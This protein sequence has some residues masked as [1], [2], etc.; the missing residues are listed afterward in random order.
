MNFKRDFVVARGKKVAVFFADLT[1]FSCLFRWS[2]VLLLAA[3]AVC[4][5]SGRG[6][7]ELASKLLGPCDILAAHQTPCVAAHSVT[8]RMSAFY[9][10]SLFQ[11]QRASD[12]AT[13]EIGSLPSG[14]VDQAAWSAFCSTTTCHYSII[15]DQMNTPNFGNN[16]SQPTPANQAPLKRTTLPN[17][18]SLPS[19][20]TVNNQ[21]YRNRSNTVGLPTGESSIT[22]YYVRSAS[23]FS[24]C[25]GDYGDMENTVHD[26]GAGTMFAL[27]FSRYSSPKGPVELGVDRE[28]GILSFGARTPA[29]FVLLGKHSQNT[30][31]TTVKL[32]NALLGALST[33]YKGADPVR[34]RLEGGLSLGEGGDGTPAPT[35]F[36]EGVVVAGETTDATD[37]LLQQNIVAFYDGSIARGAPLGPLD[38]AKDATACYSL[39]ACKVSYA[40]GR[41]N[42]ITIRRASDNLAKNIVIL[43]SGYL[44]I[45]TA[46]TFCAST[47]CFVT[48]W[49]DQTGNDNDVVQ[50]SAANQPRL[51]LNEG[52]TGSLP[53][54]AF[55]GSEWLS[56]GAITGISQ[57]LV[58]SAIAQRTGA[59]ESAGAILSA[60]NNATAF[61]GMSFTNNANKLGIYAGGQTYIFAN[62]DSWHS[63][64]ALF[65]GASSMLEVDGNV[66]SVNPGIGTI[67]KTKLVVGANNDS[68]LRQPLTGNIYE[69]ILWPSDVFARHV[70]LT[71]NQHA[72][73]GGW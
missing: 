69:A 44:D 70:D 63:I 58:I 29:I 57:P 27:A 41:N 30:Q 31:T 45:A 5:A 54:V 28:D 72:A 32:G 21:Y 71:D 48:E 65:N 24:S 55:S 49:F 4:F 73:G 18:N 53:A 34:F 64:Q 52:P 17:G 60:F 16:L 20:L 3:G 67:T 62:D 50:A 13:L 25:C 9:T 14:V 10:G 37:N 46:A 66:E 68:K 42:A 2:L 43:S 22:E 6:A 35:N 36:F 23:T 51:I 56:S 19:V 47:N 40:T 12:G 61:L 39:R 7:A 59:Y 1:P 38:L 8:R 11:L 26:D 15:Y 33:L